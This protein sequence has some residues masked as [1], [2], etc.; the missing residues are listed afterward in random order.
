MQPLPTV[1]KAYGMI[2]QE[3][4][5]REG[6]LPK[7][8]GIQV[9]LSSY[10]GPSTSR[11]T[12]YS[13]RATGTR[14]PTQERKS[15]FRPSVICSNCNKEGQYRDEC[16]KLKGCPIGHLLHGKYRLPNVRNISV[17]QPSKLVN[18]V[19]GQG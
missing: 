19:M 9:A 5:Q 14:T 13:Q 4:K 7:P 6:I 17:S 11:T 2:R 1:A 8:I 10:S 15:T 12:N 16:Y 18:S 3:K